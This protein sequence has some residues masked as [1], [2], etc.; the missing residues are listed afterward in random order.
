MKIVIGHDAFYPNVDG[1]SYFTQRLA[2][3]LKK[4]DTIFLSSPILKQR[5]A[6]A[7][8]TMAYRCFGSAPRRFLSMIIGF[9]SRLS[10]KLQN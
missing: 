3:Y 10:L 4:Q 2:L 7:M 1:A 9:T 6:T 8:F 5:Q